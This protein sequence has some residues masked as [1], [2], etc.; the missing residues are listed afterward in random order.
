MVASFDF[1]EIIPHLYPDHAVVAA[2]FKPCGEGEKV[3]LWRKPKPFQWGEVRQ[4]M[5][6]NQWKASS[7]T[8]TFQQSI[9]IAQVFEERMEQLCLDTGRRLH[10]SQ[11]G[12]GQT[13][14]T[15]TVV[16]ETRPLPKG[17]HGQLEPTFA[18][19]SHMHVKW[20]RQLRRIESLCQHLH[21]QEPNNQCILHMQREWRAICRAR[22]FIPMHVATQVNQNTKQVKGNHTLTFQDWW[23]TLSLE[24]SAPSTL[25]QCLPDIGEIKEI[26]H[27]FTKE[28]RLLEKVLNRGTI[29]MAKQNRINNPNKIFQ[30]VQKPPVAPI[31]ILD[32]SK[33]AVV[34]EAD[35]LDC[36]ITLDRE[37]RFSEDKPIT[38]ASGILK[39]I[40]LAEDKIWVEEIQRMPAGTKIRQDHFVASLDDLFQRFSDEWS[41]RWDR[42]L[43]TPDNHWDPVIDFFEASRPACPEIDLPPITPEMWYASLKAKKPHSATGPDGWSRAD[44]LAMPRDIVLELLEVLHRVEQGEEWPSTWVTGF[45]SSLEKLPSA[46]KVQHFRP[47]TIFSLIYRNWGSIR[48]RQCLKHLSLLAPQNCYGNMPH[49]SANQLWYTMQCYIE[50][51]YDDQSTMSGCL[52]DIVK[53]FNHL[54]RLPIIRASIHLG[55]PRPVVRAWS[56]ALVKLERRFAIRGSIGPP[57]RSS[58]GLAEGCA[59]SV[60]G[61]AVI[62]IMVNEWMARKQPETRVW[63]FVDNWEL[64][65][66][67]ADQIVS[68]YQDLQKIADLLDLQLDPNMLN[69]SW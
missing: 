33:E 61:M 41:A 18:G 32:E 13:L 9:F 52:V 1:A 27:A 15:K 56:N 68:S 26:L 10:P 5:P 57:L 14:M 23:K 49:R 36:T 63:S 12:R 45:V 17:R 24:S 34:V 25:P 35:P 30:D 51:A 20:F 53:A 19:I 67:N 38:A 37:V 43:S 62:N 46:S 60:V 8:S 40:F 69:F 11:K 42:H 21:N 22:G 66:K 47:I 59:M 7:D 64:T 39:P 48:A 31:T 2:F 6:D 44:L 58:T 54:P 4:K 3:Y 16:A 29:T 65:A 50:R 55:L 28:V